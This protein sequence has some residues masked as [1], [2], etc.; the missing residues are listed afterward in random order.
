MQGSVQLG[1]V[2]LAA[3][4]SL[5]LYCAGMAL[6]AIVDLEV[7]RREVPNR[8]LPR[9]EISVRA[10]WLVVVSC[11]VLALTLAA[12][13]SARVFALAAAIALLIQAYHFPF[14]SRD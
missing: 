1:R 14:K 2:A 5:L 6:N 10:A 13:A 11:L 12:L 4:A 3:L 9:G 8:P 7:D